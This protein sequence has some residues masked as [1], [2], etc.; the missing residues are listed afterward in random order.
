RSGAEPLVLDERGCPLNRTAFNRRTNELVVGR[1]DGVYFYT[2]EDRGGAAGFEGDKQRVGCLDGYI[3][4]ASMDRRSGRTAI[5]MYDLHNKFV[6]F[7]LLLPA[8]QAS[9]SL[10]NNG[11]GGRPRIGGGGGGFGGGDAAAGPD[12]NCSVAYV[13]TTSN[14][15]LRLKEK[16]MAS[17][18]ELLYRKKLYPMAISLAYASDYD[19]SIIMEI[20]RMYGDH[21]YAKGDFTGAMQQFCHTV[22]HLES[23]YVIRRFLD[24]QRIPHLTLYLEKLHDTGQATADHTTLLLNCYTKLKSVD[25]LDRFIGPDVSAPVPSFLPSFPSLSHCSSVC[26]QTAGGDAPPSSAR[27]PRFET[28]T[29]IKALKTAGYDDH[30]ARLAARHGAHEWY[31]RVQLERARP[32]VGKALE[33][34]GS[35]EFADAER[36]LKKYGKA[37]VNH[38]PQETTGIVMALCTGRYTA[39]APS[40]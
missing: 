25:K 20:Y 28:E 21:L 22:G 24:A 26:L 5:N 3:L 19:V 23:S 31:F 10:H 8:G 7:H 1:A 9:R 34:L 11:T 18:L 4:V 39:T 17:K 6:A 14:A 2:P 16:D 32:E 38:M 13:L 29:A 37:L 36:L 27:S 12:R 15:L 40:P 35:L 33:Y 30:A